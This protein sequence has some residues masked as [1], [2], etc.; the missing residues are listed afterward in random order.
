MSKTILFDVDGTLIDTEKTIIKSWQKT[1]KDTLNIEPAAEELFYVL[2]IPGTKAVQ[3]YSNGPQQSQEL[4]TLWEQNDHKMFHYS[5]LFDG[6]TTMLQQ[7]KDKNI[8]LGVVTSR[9]NKELQL[10]L[11]N[12]D[13]EKYFSTF[14][15]ASKTKLHKPNPEPILKAIETLQIDPAETLYIGD[16]IYDFQ[17]A[18]NANVEFALASWGSKDNPEFS[19]VD[20]LLKQPTDL[21]KLV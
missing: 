19:K 7:L 12:F 15:T 20:Y 1:L 10:V 8:K 6:I 17:C 3:K 21:V 14:I 18:R 2:G 5:E 11:D 4:L 9:T 16:S 13:I